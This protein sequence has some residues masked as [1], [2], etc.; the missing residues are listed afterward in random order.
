VKQ[1][2]VAIVKYKKLLDL[3][4]IQTTGER[5]EEMAVFHEHEFQN[6][7]A[8]TNTQNSFKS[9]PFLKIIL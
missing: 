2:V 5:I 1:Y 9:P 3:S 8:G 4:D 7:F 6:M